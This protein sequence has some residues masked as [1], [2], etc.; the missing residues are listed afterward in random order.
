MTRGKTTNPVLGFDYRLKPF[1]P[2]I[3]ELPD[4]T[5]VELDVVGDPNTE[6]SRLMGPLY[7]TAYGVR[8]RYKNEGQ[9]FKV[10]KL[11]GRWPEQIRLADKSTW[12]GRYGLPVPNDTDSLPPIKKEKAIPG[13]EPQLNT[14]HYGLVGQILHVG[15]YDQEPPAIDKLLVF[16]QEQGYEVIE[17]SH[18]EVYL[19]DPGKTEPEKMKTIIMYR[20]KR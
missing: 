2:K 17:G 5:M 14:W 18:E 12:R 16:V 8:K 11:R 4:Q 7:A 15:P 19:S 9:V 3:T 13:V 20:L 1:T 10:E 6:T